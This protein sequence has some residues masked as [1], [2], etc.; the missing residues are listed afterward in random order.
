M[1]N[2]PVS[3]ISFFVFVCLFFVWKRGRKIFFR[4]EMCMSLGICV[5]VGSGEG[6]RR[7]I[8]FLPGFFQVS[9]YFP[10]WLGGPKLFFQLWGEKRKKSRRSKK[11]SWPG[12]QLCFCFWAHSQNPKR[13]KKKKRFFLHWKK[14]IPWKKK[15]P[16]SVPEAFPHWL[17]F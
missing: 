16:S 11:K 7:L 8:F 13:V 1:R 15:K 10:S 17:F 9:V 4:V 14:K 5:F 2:L 12:R 3:S 6:T